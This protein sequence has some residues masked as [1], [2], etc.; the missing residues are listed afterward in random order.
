[1]LT[2]KGT[3]HAKPLQYI[4]L[5][6]F[7]VIMDFFLFVLGIIPIIFFLLYKSVQHLSDVLDAQSFVVACLFF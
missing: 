2:V 5:N 3:L 6:P 1:M 4:R 7:L